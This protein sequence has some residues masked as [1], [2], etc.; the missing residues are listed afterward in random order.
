MAFKISQSNKIPA[1]LAMQVMEQANQMQA[2]GGNLVHL[3]VGQPSSPPPAAVCRA[4]EK[5]LGHIASHGYSVAMGNPALRQRIAAHYQDWYQISADWQKIA[6]TPGSSL[7]FVIAF[8]SAFDKGDRIAIAS[9]GYPAYFNSM[10]ALGITPQLLPA[11]AAQDWKPDLEALV[12]N[13]DIPDGLLLASPANPTGVV[14][15]DV[16]L[17][18]VCR[19]CD[20]HG[21]RLIM[22]EI[23]HGLSFDEPTQSALAFTDNAIII[24]SFSKY[25]CMTGWRLGWIVL[26]DDLVQIAERLAQ[27]LYISAPSINQMGAIAAFDCYKELDAH[28]PRYQE[29]RDL[30][31]RGLPSIFLG[32]HAPSD[33][34]FYL[35]ADVSALTGDSIA[36]AGR[37]L[38]E[39][40]VAITPGVDFDAFQGRTHVRLSYAGSTKEMKKAVQRINSWLAKT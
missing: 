25:F 2:A 23:Y 16:E 15:R 3:E 31:Y 24:N 22:D 12:A 17:E 21:V 29:N 32:D 8:L 6:I 38:A 35:Y 33:G 9:P 36:F 10:L 20:K 13:G 27:N 39:T 37:L 5:S 1:F 19:W 34:A 26:P 28:I 14:M 18:A 7:G 4:L 40:G 30:L 11:R